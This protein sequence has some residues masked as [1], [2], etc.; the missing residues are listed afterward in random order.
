MSKGVKYSNAIIDPDNPF[1]KYLNDKGKTTL[2]IEQS[3]IT[4][5]FETNPPAIDLKIPI[6][7]ENARN[8]QIEFQKLTQGISEETEIKC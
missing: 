4:E 8:A 7:E 6:N 5:Y 2:S 1:Q 3:D